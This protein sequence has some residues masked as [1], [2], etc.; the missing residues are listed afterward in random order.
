MLHL[1]QAQQVTPISGSQVVGITGE[2]RGNHDT[3]ASRSLDCLVHGMSDQIGLP[4]VALLDLC[5][6]Q[7]QQSVSDRFL[8]ELREVPFLHSSTGEEGTQRAISRF[9][10]YQRPSGGT[11]PDER[12][13]SW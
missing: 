8:Y 5:H 2:C 3:H 1:P 7:I 10:N 11:H 4:N 6:G 9:R 13:A 12:Y